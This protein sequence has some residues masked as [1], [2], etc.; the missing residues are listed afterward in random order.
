MT[1]ETFNLTLEQ[2]QDYAFLVRF[3]PSL[4]ELL[5]DEPPPLGQG[6][7]PNPSRLLAASIA[8]CL[9]ASL[10]FALRKFKNDPGK[11]TAHVTGRYVRNT[12][13]RLRVGEVAV[14]I[15]CSA[16]AATMSHLERT[17]A[18][19]EEFCVVTQSVRSGFPVTV[20]IRDGT[21][22]ILKQPDAPPAV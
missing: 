4:P 19:F 9:M 14:E 11:L 18:Q 8:N 5:T 12:A 20:T 1:T 21:G 16:E 6:V 10:L 22:N 17:L 15:R 3:D 13:G 2:Q 7:G